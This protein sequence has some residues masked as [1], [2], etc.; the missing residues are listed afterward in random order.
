M[1]P[2]FSR[3]LGF[4]KL[5][6]ASESTENARNASAELILLKFGLSLVSTPLTAG[7]AT[8]ADAK[9]SLVRTR[10]AHDLGAAFAGGDASNC[11]NG[12]SAPS[13]SPIRVCELSEFAEGESATDCGFGF[14]RS[15]VCEQVW[16][17]LATATGF[18]D[19]G[20]CEEGLGVLAID[21]GFLGSDARE[22]VLGLLATDAGFLGSGVR[23]GALRLLA[24]DAGFWGF[25]VCEEA[26]GLLATA[27][28]FL[29][30]I[31]TIGRVEVLV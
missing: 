16:G 24:T 18:L 27:T 31:G 29:G 5:N 17:W 10:S 7:E 23:E 25:C 12:T 1:L 3:P 11:S 30:M 2:V 13:E 15:G 20:V 6:L 22:E 14:S 26:L 19:S 21:A 9:E 4:K 28:G 8:E